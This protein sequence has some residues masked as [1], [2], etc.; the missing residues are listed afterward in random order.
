[1]D[2]L[3]S[4]Y[5]ILIMT[6]AGPLDGVTILRFA[7]AYGSGGG[8]E[9][10]LD[11]LNRALLARNAMTIVQIQLSHA[12]VPAL[13]TEE[14]IGRG[15]LICL[16]LPIY[17]QSAAESLSDG[18][19]LGYW[20]KQLFRDWVLYN[21]FVWKIGGAKWTLSHHITPRPGQAKG[22]GVAAAEVLRT[23]RVS[24]VV[25]HFFG[26][27]DA[28]AVITAAQNA[29][30]PFV[31][32]NHYSNDR[33]LHLAVRKHAM[34]ADGV[35][36]VNGLSLPLYLRGRFT[37][38]S[39]GIDI[40][41]FRR[42]HAR[43]LVLP[44]HLPIILQPARVVREKG[45]LDLVHAAAS[46]KQS[47][48]SSFIAFAGRADSSSFIDELRHEIDRLE[49]TENVRFLGNLSVE[50]LRDWYAASTVVAF[51]T[52][53][54]EG[55]GRVIVEA[56]AVGVP[57]VAYATGGVAEGIIH[58]VTGY[59]LPTGDTRGLATY[60][61][62]LLTSP[63]MRNTMGTH[64]RSTVEKHFSLSALA[65]RHERFYVQ[66]IEESKTAGHIQAPLQ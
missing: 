32:L 64:G 36:G 2:L 7:H 52:Y 4:K 48:L 19:T 17:P 49:M 8:T 16:S 43:P 45:Q 58:G 26:G 30:V 37:N 38:L 65:D 14:S 6:T 47:G 31:I 60:L 23:H 55:L 66:I 54:H 1:M 21:P 18:L 40:E 29:G 9:R 11:D 35:S 13:P 28:E 10:Y 50:E 12:S 20:L 5:N 24:L 56:Q 39:D 34:L 27:A 62:E 22:A 15:R 57:V 41:F 33:F 51:P 61:G 59:L 44:P 25:L 3:F 42:A 63:S 46:L 53:H